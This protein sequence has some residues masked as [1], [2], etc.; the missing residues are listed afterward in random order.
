MMKSVTVVGVNGVYHFS[1]NFRSLLTLVIRESESFFIT[2]YG[3][4]DYTLEVVSEIINK[5]EVNIL[6]VYILLH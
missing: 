4:P 2:I 1:T 5:T 6:N 3:H